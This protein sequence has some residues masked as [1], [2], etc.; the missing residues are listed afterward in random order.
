MSNKRKN[1]KEEKKKAANKKEYWT[2][3]TE[4]AVREYLVNDFNFYAV[5]WHH[6]IGF[7]R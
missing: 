5:Y 6:R 7:G 3:E 2:S 1:H 4:E